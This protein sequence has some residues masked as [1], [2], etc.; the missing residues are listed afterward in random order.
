MQALKGIDKS[1]LLIAVISVVSPFLMPFPGSALQRMPQPRRAVIQNNVI[2]KLQK[3]GNF[4]LFL[5]ALNET[6]LANALETGKG[7]YTIFAPNDRAFSSLSQQTFKQ[8]FADKA[9][10]KNVLRYHIVQRKLVS[11]GIKYDAL[12]TLSGEFLMSNV[13]S[14]HNI[15]VG[16]A[17]V[18][19][20]DMTCRN[21]VVHAIDQVLF[22]Q[23]GME[24]LALGDAVS[25]V[26]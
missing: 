18:T 9:R 4:R 7:P 16:G 20:G 3:E 25:N 8:L 2:Q 13:N 19:K 6:G 12:R 14:A 15:T 24:S 10:L 22:P 21:G 5:S 1:A 11:G 23:T 26:H 17:L